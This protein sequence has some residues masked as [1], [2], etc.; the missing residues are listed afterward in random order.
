MSPHFQPLP[1]AIFEAIFSVK[2]TMIMQIIITMIK[3]MMILS[4]FNVDALIFGV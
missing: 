3:N 4:I 2:A 1:Y